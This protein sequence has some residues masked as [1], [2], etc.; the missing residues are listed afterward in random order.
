ME[1]NRKNH[2]TFEGRTFLIEKTTAQNTYS[3]VEHPSLRA[4]RLLIPVV[5]E[6]D[7]FSIE[8]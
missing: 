5:N 4:T 8:V 1:S 6:F 7:T 2:L 3:V